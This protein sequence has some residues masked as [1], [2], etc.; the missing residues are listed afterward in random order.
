MRRKIEVGDVFSQLTVTEVLASVGEGKNKRQHYICLCSC[1]NLTKVRRDS[2]TSGHTTSC[3]CFAVSQTIK[4]S[5]KHGGC[6]TPEYQAWINIRKRCYWEKHDH[7]AYYGGRG[8][9][10]CDKW[11][12]SFANFLNDVGYRPS[13]EHSI[14]RI[15]FNGDYEPSNVRWATQLEQARNK[16]NNRLIEY[17]GVTRCLA[18]WAELY[19]INSSKIHYWARQGLSYREALHLAIQRS[20]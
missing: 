3:G 15:D 19:E 12:K 9:K 16:S 13:N 6:G 17:N 2:L 5:K 10:V 7:F 18:E 1:G 4:R 20:S 8:I 14:E 11:L